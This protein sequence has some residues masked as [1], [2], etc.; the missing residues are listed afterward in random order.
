MSDIKI[1][2]NLYDTTLASGLVGGALCVDS[3]SPHCS[4]ATSRSTPSITVLYKELVTVLV[5]Y[6][7]VVQYF[8]GPSKSDFF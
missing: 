8:G 1:K 3:P 5:L 2:N 4:I 6:Y 7:D